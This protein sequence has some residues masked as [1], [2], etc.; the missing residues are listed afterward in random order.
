MKPGFKLKYGF[1]SL[2]GPKKG[3]VHYLLGG[4]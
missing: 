1:Q 4:A 2:L 3:V